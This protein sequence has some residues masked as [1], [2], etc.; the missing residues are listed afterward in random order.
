MPT[1]R[2]SNRFANDV[3]VVTYEFENVPAATA[4]FLAARTPVLPDRKV[5]AT[6]QDRLIEKDFVKRLGIGTA[7][8]TPTCRF[9]RDAARGDRRASACPP[10]SR[11]AASAMTA[12]ARR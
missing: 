10:C 1:S 11:P 6:T 3:D 5:L 2:R 7:R 9:G 12:R 4:T 8:L